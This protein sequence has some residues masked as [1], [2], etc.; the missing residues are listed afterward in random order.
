MTTR[1]M[2]VPVLITIELAEDGPQDTGAS[3]VDVIVALD[4]WIANNTII[5]LDQDADD[6]VADVLA[7]VGAPLGGDVT[8]PD[9][10]SV[11]LG[12]W[13]DHTEGG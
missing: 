1:R 8:L 5:E 2:T 4:E 10:T 12:E 7:V 11:R 9:G 6:V 3:D 13:Y